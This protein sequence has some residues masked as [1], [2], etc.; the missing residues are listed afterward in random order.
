MKCF[1]RL[2]KRDEKPFTS[3]WKPTI[4]HLYPVCVNYCKTK[5][6]LKYVY[7]EGKWITN[8]EKL[9]RLTSEDFPFERTDKYGRWRVDGQFKVFLG[10]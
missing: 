10:K 7:S 2:F 6:K 8:G 4:G 9:L 3:K 5:P 1:T